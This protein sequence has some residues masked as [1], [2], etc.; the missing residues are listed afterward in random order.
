MPTIPCCTKI[1][2]PSDAGNL[3]FDTPISNFSSEAPDKDLFICINSGWGSN[4]PPLGWCFTDIN[5]LCIQES[6]VSQADACQKAIDCQFLT[7]VNG[8]NSGGPSWNPN[9]CM[10]DPPPLNPGPGTDGGGGGNPPPTFGGGSNNPGPTIYANQQQACSF[11]CADGLQFTWTIAAGVIHQPT[12]AMANALAY[13]LACE[14]AYANRICLGTLTSRACVNQPYDST[15][16]IDGVHGPFT[17]SVTSGSYPPGLT[18]YSGTDG[19]SFQLKGTPTTAGDYTF[20]L[21]ATDTSGNFMQKVYTIHVLGI[22]NAT[23]LAHAM[24]GRAYSQQLNG[25]GGTSPFTYLVVSG[26]LGSNL[27]VS[28]SGLITGTPNYLTKGANTAQVKIT[29]AGGNSCTQNVTITTDVAPGPNWDA[30]VWS[31]PNNV[32]GS[33][34][35]SGRQATAQCSSNGAAPFGFVTQV[36]ASGVT[37]T[38]PSVNARVQ[39][40]ISYSGNPGQDNATMNLRKAGVVITGY[41]SAFATGTYNFDFATGVGAG[42][43]W[44]FDDAGP[45]NYFIGMSG[46]GNVGGATITWSIFNL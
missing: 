36:T 34:S 41:G 32:N 45:A 14:Y 21:T 3:D 2:C 17:T 15:V 13:S 22:T 7:T 4:L 40:T 31:F 5:L 18:P 30:F 29:D 44:T 10:T 11:I 35:G 23:S 33:G 8:G 16:I 9:G 37:Y 25:A 43:A 20:T 6:A 46:L 19:K 27:T 26:S 42:E 39:I 24:E 28:T 1:R 12:L 38:G